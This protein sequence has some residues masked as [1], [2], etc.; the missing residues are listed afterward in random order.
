MSMPWWKVATPHRDVREGVTGD[1]AADLY[2]IIKG[3][4]TKEYVDP[5]TFFKRTHITKGLENIVKDTLTTLTEGKTGKIIQIQTPFGGGK[6]HALITLYHLI[7]NAKE[8]AD[9]EEVKRLLNSNG[10]NAI[11]EAKVAVFVG[12][13]PDPLRGKT[14]WGEIAEQLGSYDLVKEH[15]EKRITPGREILQRI[16]NENKPVLI[17]MDEIAVYT[18]K[19]KEFEDQILAFCQELTEAVKATPQCVL[20]CTLPSSAPYGERGERILSQLQRIFG[21]MQLIYTPVEGEEIYEIIRKRLFEDLGNPTIH[22]KVA[23]EYF[24]LYQR[25][26]EKVPSDAREI[27]Y[28]EKIK[29]AYPFHPEIIDVLFERWGS[30]PTFQRTRGVL[31]LLA[32]VIADLIK[33]GHPAPLIQPAHINL[34]EPKI[35][36]LF[37]EHIGEV[38]VSVIAS[39]IAGTSAKAPM[40][41]RQMGSEYARFNVA[42]GIATAIFFYSFSGGEKRGVSLQRLRLAFLTNDIPPTIVDEAIRKLEEELWYLHIEKNLYYFSNIASLNRVIVEKEEA[43]REEDIEKELK[44]RIKSI[45]GTD[46]DIYIWPKASN[47]IP[48][49]K[50]LKLA[51]LSPILT[52][53]KSETEELAEDLINNYSSSFRV[54]KNTLLVLIADENEYVGLRTITRR[55]LALNAIKSEKDTMRTLT[56]EDK[57]RVSQKL[58]DADASIAIKILSTYRYIAKASKD[59][60]EILDMGIPTVGERP[61]LSRRVKQ[62]LKDEEILLDRISPKALYD[63]AFPKEEEEVPITNLWTAFL[64]IPELP[65]LSNENVLLNAVRQGV[66]EGTFGVRI[67]ERLYYKESLPEIELTDQILIIKRE[68]AE[69]HKEEIEKPEGITTTGPSGLSPQSEKE[70]SEPSIVLRTV[71]E[72]KLKAV[73]PWERLSDFIGGVI[74]PLARE[75]AEVVLRVEVEAR[76]EKGVDRNIIEGTIKETLNQIGA[77]IIEEEEN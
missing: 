21:R 59:G 30:L 16:L 4:A 73:V 52:K 45:S 61:N 77:K 2:Q 10:I 69:R 38:F 62:F 26:G 43:I 15:D 17:L 24:D 6:T 48:D 56:D 27:R 19:A 67:G 36:R 55:F 18:V 64:Q 57:K 20:V 9:L 47:D 70:V 58:K 75:G 34:A 3:E 40:I 44:E 28:K 46:F 42:T 71:K 32:E 33:R 53:G 50:Q 35:R 68:I 60:I 23:E 54:Y 11:P 25:L 5:Q 22:E 31:R 72:L 49:N 65:I 63:K 66:R 51:I 14:P 29:K 74:N 41:D 76:S 12:T 37:V 1:F 7:K 39:D 8:V 13:I